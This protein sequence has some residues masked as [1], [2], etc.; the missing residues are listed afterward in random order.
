MVMVVPVSAAFED[1][2]GAAGAEDAKGQDE[3]HPSGEEHTSNFPKHCFS[4]LVKYP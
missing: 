4:P 2:A 1:A 3:D